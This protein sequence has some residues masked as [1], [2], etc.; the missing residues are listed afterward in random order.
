MRS[1]LTRTICSPN[2][3]LSSS[4]AGVAVHLHLVLSGL[5]RGGRD[6][7]SEENGEKDRGD[8]QLHVCSVAKSGGGVE[9]V[10]MGRLATRKGKE[11]VR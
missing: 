5:E 2:S 9:R 10:T 6:G 8:R 4:L 3:G 11:N 7:G 1:R